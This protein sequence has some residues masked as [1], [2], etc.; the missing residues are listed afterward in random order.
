MAAARKAAATLDWGRLSALSDEKL[1]TYMNVYLTRAGVPEQLHH[2]V[3][4]EWVRRL[5]RDR[6]VTSR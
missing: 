6:K 2:S 1:D 3:K 4:A 5:S